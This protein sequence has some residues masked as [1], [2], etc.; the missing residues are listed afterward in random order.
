MIKVGGVESASGVAPARAVGTWMD[1]GHM[2]AP[3]G[4]RQ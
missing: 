2:P 4:F 1:Y 3:R